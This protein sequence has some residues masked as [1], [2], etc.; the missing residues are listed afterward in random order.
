MKFYIVFVCFFVAAGLRA[1]NTDC[2]SERWSVKNLTDA[3]TLKIDFQNAIV[4]LIAVQA[5]FPK[6]VTRANDAR[7]ASEDTLYSV[8]CNLIAYKLE[9]DGDYHLQLRDPVTDSQMVGEIPNPDCLTV[10]DR[11]RGAWQKAR[12]FID[13]AYGPAKT[14]FR[15]LPIP[16]KIAI[17]GFGYYD[18]Y[19]GQTGFAANNRELHPV[20]MIGRAT[21]V[22]ADEVPI[23]FSGTVSVYPNPAG[24]HVIVEAS[25][26]E[27]IERIV[28]EDLRGKKVFESLSHEGNSFSISVP[29]SKLPLGTY[30][31][32]VISKSGYIVRKFEVKK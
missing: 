13:T 5:R 2:G 22:V 15:Y 18:P 17:R 16:V 8:I 21:D 6:I 4:S 10:S 12:M 11:W 23:G 1:Q 20:M 30:F 28:I 19:H 25:L 32:R 9:A 29:T 7:I 31:A 26:N 3:D 14:S 27:S 24:D